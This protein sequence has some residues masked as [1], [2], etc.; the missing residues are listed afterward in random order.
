LLLILYIEL[1]APTRFSAKPPPPNT[2]LNYQP[3][4]KTPGF[5]TES[6]RFFPKKD[7]N[8]TVEFQKGDKDKKKTLMFAKSE[9][10]RSNMDTLMQ[11]VCEIEVKKEAF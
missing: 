4:P 8:A 9:A 2:F 3:G 7:I 11:K 1:K 10:K 5:I 6:E